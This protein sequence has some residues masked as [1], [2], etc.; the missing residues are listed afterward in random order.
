MSMA[1]VFVTD[2]PKVLVI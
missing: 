2:V 1:L